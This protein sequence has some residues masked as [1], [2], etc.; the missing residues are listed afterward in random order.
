[1]SFY[2]VIPSIVLYSKHLT[3]EEKILYSILTNC[4]IPGKSYCNITNEELSKILNTSVRTITSRLDSMQKKGFVICKVNNHLHRRL[5]F[6]KTPLKEGTFENPP[7]EEE[8]EPKKQLLLEAFKKATILGDVDFETL[9][10]RF[11]DSPYLAEVKSGD[12]QFSLNEE[13][14][15]FLADFKKSYPDKK[16]D[17]QLAYYSKINLKA[18]SQAIKESIFLQSNN[19][20]SLSWLLKNSDDIIAGKYKNYG[21]NITEINFNGRKYKN[22]YLNSMFQTLDEIEI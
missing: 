18:F 1:M 21:E 16:I 5:V 8:L 20:L 10:Q 14:L 11:I 9:M 15:M 13:Q 4:I 17:A 2:T 6:L 7:T 3:D 22:G 19:N 12:I